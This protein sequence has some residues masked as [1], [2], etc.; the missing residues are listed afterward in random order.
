MSNAVRLPQPMTVE[1]FQNWVPPAGLEN[2]RWHLVNGEP[3]CMAPASDDHSML[4]ATVNALLWQHLS[5]QRSRCRVGIAPGVI[6]RVGAKTNELV[7]D[8]G[9][10]C[11]PALGGKTM[12]EPVLLVE[13]I[14]PSNRKMTERNILAYATIP[15]VREILSLDSL[16][17][18]GKLYRR[19]ASGD[20]ESDP[21]PLGPSDSV[22]L[23]SIGFE[24]PLA[25]FYATSSLAR[26]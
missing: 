20:W 23:A 4:Q 25:D 2:R 10:T 14:S 21:V 26:G 1:G 24:A 18:A 16:S 12:T 11:S 19:D 9:V 13:I 8:I 6:P 22:R 3:V 5:A 7:P 15:S 17:V